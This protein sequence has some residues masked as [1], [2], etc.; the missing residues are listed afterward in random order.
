ML[1]GSVCSDNP[2]ITPTLIKNDI[3]PTILKSIQQKIPN[4]PDMLE[5]L[6]FA[7]NQMSLH[8]EG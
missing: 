1:V 6:I 2:A 5:S 4:S 3:I 7:I 8:E